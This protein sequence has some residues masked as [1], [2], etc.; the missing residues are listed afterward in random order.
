MKEYD[1]LKQEL[2]KDKKMWTIIKADNKK[3]EFLKKD[4]VK[5]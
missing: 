5:N 2:E 4:L 1:E 3:I